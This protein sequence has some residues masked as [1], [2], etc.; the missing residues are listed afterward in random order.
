M[1]GGKKKGD[2]RV[3]AIL[4]AEDIKYEVDSDGDYKIVIGFEDNRSQAVFIN[5][6]TENFAGVEIREVW[7]I[8]LRGSGQLS[9]EMANEL[10]RR[11]SQYKVGGWSTVQ[12]EGQLF[13]LME[14]REKAWGWES[15]G[16]IGSKIHLPNAP[17]IYIRIWY[18]KRNVGKNNEIIL[19][20]TDFGEA[21][22]W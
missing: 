7:S 6:N 8:G 16:Y 20:I 11:N 17:E 5:S 4:E 13:M 15:T 2:P 3:R 14:K 9:A 19:I 12:S 21:L 22:I 10:L 1:F 18:H